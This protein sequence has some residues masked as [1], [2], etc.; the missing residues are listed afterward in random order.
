MI[1]KCLNLS[2]LTG[3]NA[4]LVAQVANLD[5]ALTIT[6]KCL[7]GVDYATSIARPAFFW[8]H[9]AQVAKV[10]CYYKQTMICA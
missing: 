2:E 4:L 6:V 3:M 9:N 5:R 8:L 10:T 1:K 7:H